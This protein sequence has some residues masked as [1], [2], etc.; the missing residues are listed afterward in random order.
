MQKHFLLP[1]QELISDWDPEMLHSCR[2][3]FFC[4]GRDS[5]QTGFQKCHTHAETISFALAGIILRLTPG[6]APALVPSGPAD[7]PARFQKCY[8]H[9][10]TISFALAGI[11]LTLGTRNATLMQKQFLFPWQGLISD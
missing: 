1:W 8:T 2:N 10:E 3:N 7:F 5:S 9:V 4:L 6:P 11:H